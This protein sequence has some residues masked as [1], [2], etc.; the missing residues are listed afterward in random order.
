MLAG[1]VWLCAAAGAGTQLASRGKTCQNEL[2]QRNHP[3]PEAC[4]VS[5]EGSFG[6]LW[7]SINFTWPVTRIWI[8]YAVTS[9]HCENP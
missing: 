9:H 7:N 2:R 4:C 6:D 3:T 1:C 8:E 5:G